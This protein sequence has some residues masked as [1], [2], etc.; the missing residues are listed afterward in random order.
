MR[1]FKRRKA[2][3]TDSPFFNL[4]S[5]NADSLPSDDLSGPAAGDSSTILPTVR[6]RTVVFPGNAVNLQNR[7]NFRQ[8]KMHLR[9]LHFL[10]R[11]LKRH[12]SN[13]RQTQCSP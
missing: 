11:L 10:I 6:G 12:P 9:G 3:S 8:N 1:F 13:T 7:L 5:V 4:I 2:F